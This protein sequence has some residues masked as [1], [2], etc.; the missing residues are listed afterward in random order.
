MLRR[1]VISVYTLALGLMRSVWR[2]FINLDALRVFSEGRKRKFSRRQKNNV[3]DAVKAKMEENM[4]EKFLIKY[5]LGTG[6]F[7]RMNRSPLS[8]Y[9]ALMRFQVRVSVSRREAKIKILI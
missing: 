9:K 7:C 3:K 5:A 4:N 1:R 2:N 6:R 8:F